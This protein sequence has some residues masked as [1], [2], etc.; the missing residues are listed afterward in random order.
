MLSRYYLGGSE[1][2][3]GRA[4]QHLVGGVMKLPA[5]LPARIRWS[6]RAWAYPLVF[7]L[8]FGLGFTA[9]MVLRYGVLFFHDFSDQLPTAKLP[10][11]LRTVLAIL[12]FLIPL[13]GG[14]SLWWVMAWA[15][16]I[17]SLYMKR[18]EA[19]AAF[20]WVLLLA[21]APLV[22]G[23][24]ARFASAMS[25]ETL[26]ACLRVRHG[27]PRP[28]DRVILEKARENDPEDLAAS[29]AWPCC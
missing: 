28:D 4:F 21:L 5:D 26:A 7:H 23:K 24:Y 2:D 27:V 14:L 29:S 18:S 13:A 20:L 8:V 1:F 16:M 9:V 25:E 19:G 12:L 11:S 15:L 22:L 10:A 17:F 6:T 3:L